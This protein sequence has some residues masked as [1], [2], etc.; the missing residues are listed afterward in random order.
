VAQILAGCD[1]VSDLWLELFELGE[2]TA[3][4]SSGGL[5]AGSGPSGQCPKVDGDLTNV[6]GKREELIV[7]F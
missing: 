2:A 1:A 3:A 4:V 6:N 7:D 5:T